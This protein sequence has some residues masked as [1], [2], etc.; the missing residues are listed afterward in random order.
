MGAAIAF[1]CALVGGATNP[2]FAAALGTATAASQV[3]FGKQKGNICFKLPIDTVISAVVGASS[4]TAPSPSM[5]LQAVGNAIVKHA[6]SSF[7]R[8]P[9]VPGLAYGSSDGVA[10]ISEAVVPLGAGAAEGGKKQAK[11]NYKPVQ[12]MLKGYGITLV[13]LPPTGAGV[14]IGNDK[15]DVKLQPATGMLTVNGVSAPTEKI[16]GKYCMTPDAFNE[17]MKKAGVKKKQSV[18]KEPVDINKA[19]DSLVHSETR[20]QALY[21]YLVTVEGFKPKAYYASKEERAKGTL[22]IGV[23]YTFD[24]GT[25]NYLETATLT[26]EDGYALFLDTTGKYDEHIIKYMKDNRI[27]LNENQYNSL[28]SS[29]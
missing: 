15:V 18:E 22:T 17:L 2:L 29:S 6:A 21:D 3:K 7:V 10:I 27:L 1:S 8:P 9:E 23:G 14:G 25:G 11:K 26:E 24:A 28:F 5:G 20:I 19:I 4:Q 12:D 13:Y 16:L